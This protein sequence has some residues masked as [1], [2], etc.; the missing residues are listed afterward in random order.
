M[1][2]KISSWNISTIKKVKLLPRTLRVLFQRQMTNSMRGVSISSEAFAKM[3]DVSIAPL[4][5]LELENNVILKNDGDRIHLVKYCTSFDDKRCTGGQFFFTPKEW[6]VFWN[7]IYNQIDQ[8]IT[9]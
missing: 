6:Q 4:M 8:Q 9:R 5:S 2:P 1:D 7:E 3:D